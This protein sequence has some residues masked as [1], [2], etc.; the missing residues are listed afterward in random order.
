[1]TKNQRFLQILLYCKKLVDFSLNE[2]NSSTVSYQMCNFIT[3]PITIEADVHANATTSRGIPG[4]ILDTA[5]SKRSFMA[6]K[7]SLVT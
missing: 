2:E 5:S 1:M 7:V 4:K 6:D 3:H